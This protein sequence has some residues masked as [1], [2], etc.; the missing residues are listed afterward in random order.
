[1]IANPLAAFPSEL[2]PT[3]QFAPSS[4]QRVNLS[5][6]DTEPLSYQ[7]DL[8]AVGTVLG[9]SWFVRVNQ[10]D[11]ADRMGWQLAEARF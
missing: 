2:A 11:T 10:T 7:G 9:G 5:E 6:S 4:E 8:T 3:S 1:M